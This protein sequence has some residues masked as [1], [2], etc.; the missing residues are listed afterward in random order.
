[1]HIV[2]SVLGKAEKTRSPTSFLC[3]V[4]KPGLENSWRFGG[5]AWGGGQS[6]KSREF[7]SHI[8]P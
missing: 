3:R 1:M 4:A 6:E 2:S 5:E 7:S 8:I